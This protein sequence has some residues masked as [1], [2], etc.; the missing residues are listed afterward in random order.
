MLMALL[1]GLLASFWTS[2]RKP[3]GPP[4]PKRA[5]LAYLTIPEPA[6]LLLSLQIEGEFMRVEISREQLAGIVV[7]GTRELLSTGGGR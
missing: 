5:S 6:V 1:R 4:E 2:S 7:V 3:K